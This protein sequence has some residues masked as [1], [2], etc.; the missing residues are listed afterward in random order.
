MPDIR[1]RLTFGALIAMLEPRGEIPEIHLQHSNL[2]P[3]AR[4]GI[5]AKLLGGVYRKRLGSYIG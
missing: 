1:A 2:N 3:H 5:I 4:E